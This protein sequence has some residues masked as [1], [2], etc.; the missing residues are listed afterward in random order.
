MSI[1]QVHQVQ[2]FETPT[3]NEL[4]RSV[5]KGVRRTIGTAQDGKAPL[6]SAD[7]K[8]IVGSLP[9]TLIGL[10]DRALLLVGFMELSAVPN[11]LP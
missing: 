5:M 4:V 6:V 7:I 9:A 2:G 1:S 8:E 10:R 3:Q 11:W